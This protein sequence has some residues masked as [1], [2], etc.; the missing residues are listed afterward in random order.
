MA[1]PELP[2][3]RRAR[4][5]RYRGGDAPER[6]GRRRAPEDPPPPGPEAAADEQDWLLGTALQHGVA[7]NDDAEDAAEPAPRGVRTRQAPETGG[8]QPRGRRYRNGFEEL[9]GE[10]SARRGA[11]GD[12]NGAP[13][14]N[15]HGPAGHSAGPGAGGNGTH[16]RP[17]DESSDPLRARYAERLRDARPYEAGSAQG[18][19]RRRAD[20]RSW[21][22]AGQPGGH[23]RE[24]GAPPP[25]GDA[26]GAHRRAPEGGAGSRRRAPEGG[27]GRH[28]A[29][30]GGP[31]PSDAPPARNQGGHDDRARYDHAPTGPDGAAGRPRRP[32]PDAGPPRRH[33]DTTAF[34]GAA[35][36]SGRP[37]R[38]GPPPD[39][40][41]PAGG[42]PEH[43]PREPRA[44]RGPPPGAAAGPDGGM[45][46]RHRGPQAPPDVPAGADGGPPQSPRGPQQPPPRPPAGFGGPA[47]RQP[48][49]PQAPP[50]GYRSPVAP[51]FEPGGAPAP[52]RPAPPRGP[53]PPDAPPAGAGGPVRPGPVPGGPAGNRGPSPAEDVDPDEDFPPDSGAP[54]ATGTVGRISRR[55]RGLGEPPAGAGPGTDESSADPPDDESETGPDAA[56]DREPRAGRRP[57]PVGIGGRL[58]AF[59]GLGKDADGEKRQLSFW[60]E[61][62][63]LAGV[64]I[65]LTILIQTF[66]AKV[67][68][69]PSGSMETTLHGCTGCTNDRVL[70]DK[71]T[72]NFTD[73]SPGDIVVFRGTDGWASESY[74]G[75]GSENP[76]LRGLESLGSLVGIAPPDE[77][78][79]VKRVIAVGG[80]TVACCDALNQVMV[81]GQPL[82]EPYVYYLPEAGPARQ[83]PFGPVTVP[84]GEYW[85]MGDSRNNSADSRAAGHGPIPDENIIG[86][87]RLVVL[88]FD[89]FGWVSAV[90]PQTTA[91]AAATPGLPDGVPLALGIMGAFPLAVGR[92]RTL[93]A[94][95][96]AER[97]LPATRRPPRWRRRS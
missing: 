53:V 65:L 18:T 92:R 16:G 35:P 30:D 54:E 67:Y 1:F 12:G 36:A 84:E 24:T 8:E 5:R 55:R 9:A 89:R 29:Y 57:G 74:T 45:S 26:T 25:P 46:Q 43:A 32:G 86:K 93:R 47:P 69:I 11:H 33:G 64:A 85:M 68:V 40:S 38:G 60:K 63:L 78:D 31:V 80:Q 41:G 10:R 59:A 3:D 14:A 66:L 50:D 79:F 87:V 21:P 7:V 44:R 15:G 81:D 27:T 73:I 49:G 72:Y 95:A 61:L 34:D 90:D 71:V 91:T 75:E 70:V 6:T 13:P 94:R 62:L 17:D 97:F 19:G 83:I 56:E 4:P 22:P 48:R 82:E 42:P 77:K 20:E 88:P 51:G 37:R 96:E 2:D 76:L 28:G 23:R 52:D 39:A 58:A